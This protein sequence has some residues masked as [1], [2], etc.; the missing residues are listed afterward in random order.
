M[1]I[2]SPEVSIQSIMWWLYKNRFEK[3]YILI[4]IIISRSKNN[5][6]FFVWS[7]SFCF[8]ILS[9]VHDWFV[10]I[11]QWK[12]VIWWGIRQKLT[13]PLIFVRVAKVKNNIYNLILEGNYRFFRQKRTTSIT[14]GRNN[15]R[16]FPQI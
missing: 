6:L 15:P 11:G 7:T 13:T 1:Y 14:A 12:W 3:I 8:E 4:F 2:S 10:L 16:P 9:Q 5:I